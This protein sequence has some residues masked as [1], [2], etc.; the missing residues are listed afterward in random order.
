MA[1]V[2]FLPFSG[3][4]LLDPAVVPEDLAPRALDLE[5][6]ELRCARALERPELRTDMRCVHLHRRHTGCDAAVR[7]ARRDAPPARVNPRD[8]VKLIINL[9]QVYICDLWSSSPAPVHV[10]NGSIIS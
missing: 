5:H 7:N 10:A 3:E 1:F 9:I 2:A 4:K 8:Q 6:G